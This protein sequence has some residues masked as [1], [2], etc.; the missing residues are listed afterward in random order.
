MQTK[1]TLSL[2]DRIINIAKVYSQKKNRSI[3]KMVEDYFSNLE[4]I[5]T[6]L[7]NSLSGEITDK[8]AGMFKEEYN[9]EDYKSLLEQALVERY[10]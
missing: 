10:L 8:I 3:S 4:K 1:L 6:D 2:D 5:D 9:G 7:N